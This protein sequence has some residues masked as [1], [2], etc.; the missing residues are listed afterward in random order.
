NRWRIVPFFVLSAALH[1]LLLWIVPA[2][3]DTAGLKVQVL[4]LPPPVLV[5]PKPAFTA[6]SPRLLQHRLER[7]ELPAGPESP[8]PPESIPE[9]VGVGK[10]P[11]ITPF[12]ELAIDTVEVAAK[13]RKFQAPLVEMPDLNELALRA[14]RERAKQAEQHVRFYLEAV[15]P[16]TAAYK[17]RQRAEEIVERAIA[18]MG[19]DRALASIKGARVKMSIE[20]WD[21][22][23]GRE[24]LQ[25]K[26]Y[27]YPVS[28]QHYKVGGEVTDISLEEERGQA[29]AADRGRNPAESLS[30]YYRLFSLR[31][32]FL[33]PARRQSRQMGEMRRWH[34][35][36][37]FFGEGV[38]LR[39][40]QTE[41]FRDRLTDVIRV[42][43]T[44]Y[45]N[46][47]DALFS[48]NTGLLVATR[49]RLTAAEQR[50]YSQNYRQKPPVWTTTYEDYEAVQGIL[51]PR[52]I[53]RTG[54]NCP[55][56]RTVD[57]RTGR[58]VTIVIYAET[59]YDIKG[60]DDS[61]SEGVETAH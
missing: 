17:S 33:T 36:D 61:L 26:P 55:S 38:V 47:Y 43:D 23:T 39:Y 60:A 58:S 40:I 21:H 11:V 31:W 5:M 13:A 46:Y 2:G 10:L 9:V 32:D 29:V 27:L 42:D 44:L 48:R 59:T 56:C 54:P 4:R 35:F 34:F 57:E 28:N 37:R 6:D 19:G 7:L 1:L 45:G 49:D 22:R 16:G 53:E 12:A 51:T 25:V 41:K 14:V 24:V 30:R 8:N 18:A 3:R 52:R 15:T 50:D 20:A